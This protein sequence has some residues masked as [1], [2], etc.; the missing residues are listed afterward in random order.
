[1]VA[2]DRRGEV[3]QSSSL[4]GIDFVE[5][6]AADQKT[7]RVHF[8][9]NKVMLAGTVT[10]AR[11]TGGETVPEVPPHKIDD[12]ADWSVDSAGN[13]LLT[14]RVDAPGDF[15]NYTLTLT[16]DLL[17]P[18]FASEQFS[19]KALCPSTLD[20]EAPPPACPGPAGQL[21]PIDYLAKDFQSFRK[22]LSDFSGLRYPEWQERSE[23][24]FGV[25]FLESLSSLGDDLSY[26][27]DRV[28][29]E[30]TLDTA[31]QRRSLVRHARLVDYEPRPATIA[32][33]LLQFE[34]GGGPIPAGVLV[35]AAGADGAAIYFETGTG[36]ADRTNYAADSK[37]N[38]LAPYW[39]DDSQR[40]LPRGSTDMWV[41]GHGLNLAS[42][43]LLL[44]ETQ[45][46]TT[47][48]PPLRQIVQ[49]NATPVEA[50]DPIFGP[51]NVTHIFWRSEDAL[52]AGRDLTQTVVKGNMVPATEGRRYSESF[53]IEEAPPATPHL[54]LAIFRTGANG[55]AVYNYTL[56]SAPLAW[57]AP[58]DPTLPPLPEIA[59]VDSP[60]AVAPRTWTWFRSLLEAD[61]FE[62]GFALD[63]VRF[64]PVATIPQLSP[65]QS[66][67][68]MDYDGNGGDTIRFGDG[69]FGDIPEDQTVF[70]VTY[71]A[72]GGS[73]GNV[74]ADSITRI[75]VP[76]GL[77]IS[78]NNPF[79]A[80][81][82]AE[83]EPALAVRRLAPQ[84]FRA[85]QFRAVIAKDYEAAAET[86]PWVQRAGTV[87]RWTGSWLTVFTTADPIGSEQ[88]PVERHVQL[89]ELLNRYRLAGY[90]SFA[91]DPI[92]AALDLVITV[93][94]QADSFRGDVEAAVLRALSTQRFPDGATG[95]FQFERFTFGVPLER[96]ALEAAIQEAQGVAGVLCIHFRRRGFT[97]GFIAMPDTVNVAV[98]E[99][100]LIE[101]DP[102]RPE[103]GSLQV[104]VKGGK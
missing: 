19:F 53:A 92:Y 17:D 65:A 89:I 27:Q 22:A 38:S 77:L 1:M 102:S 16:S 20:C 94:A 62:A 76:T 99:I 29:A 4:N 79:P 42:G 97:A 84:A 96:S 10:N 74:P 101:N 30:A 55:S 12:A 14:L 33:V 52:T 47:A 87:F 13:P 82:G 58:D 41:E 59:M 100:I 45:P 8:L 73:T 83:P 34:T 21:P 60:S 51:A 86:L 64:A 32:K 26:T 72:G 90:E 35:S 93:C 6:A 48:D 50:V 7:L 49:L 88:I 80:T 56:G 37:W 98:N 95:F 70:A 66:V 71:R 15:S 104:I 31:T 44:I 3:I 25:M 18:V 40:C 2:K 67:I 69:V 39:F 61:A 75:E 57:L 23:A 11:I 43:Q 5:I 9:N 24:D 54:P 46:P 85:Q 36:L 81:G 28:A 91:P 103:R 78:V 63:P 68:M